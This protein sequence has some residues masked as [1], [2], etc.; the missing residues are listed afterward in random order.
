MS[1]ESPSL[2]ESTSAEDVD[3]RAKRTSGQAPSPARH[4]DSAPEITAHTP[5]KVQVI[6]RNGKVT[7]FDP[8][9]IMVAMTKAFLAVEGG[10]AAASSRVHDRVRELAEQVTSALTRRLPGGGTVHIED[11]QDQ[12]ELALMRAGEHKVAR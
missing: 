5:G 9:K 1:T 11:I 8:N 10:S 7:H 6:R 12:V 3:V 2:V 4:S